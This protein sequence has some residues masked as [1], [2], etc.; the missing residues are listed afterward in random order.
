MKTTS[1]HVQHCLSYTCH[2]GNSYHTQCN[3]PLDK[4][5]HYSVQYVYTHARTALKCQKRYHEKLLCW[6]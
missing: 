2:I 1:A 5:L 3:Q 6:N 4:S